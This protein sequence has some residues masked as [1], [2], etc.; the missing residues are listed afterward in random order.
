MDPE[1]GD[2]D[3]VSFI[4]SG[5]IP[6]YLGQAWVLVHINPIIGESIECYCINEGV[7]IEVLRLTSR[8][9]TWPFL[10]LWGASAT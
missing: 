6:R 10:R 3:T 8:P 5:I 9:G 2:V 7:S 1:V 4:K